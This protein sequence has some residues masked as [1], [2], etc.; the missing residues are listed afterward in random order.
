MNVTD[1][2]MIRIEK[3][4]IYKLLQPNLKDLRI[5]ETTNG[6]IIMLSPINA[7]FTMLLRILAGT[8]FS[9]IEIFDHS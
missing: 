4:R 5:D 1:R 9:S 2:T 7:A 3:F 8:A 6:A